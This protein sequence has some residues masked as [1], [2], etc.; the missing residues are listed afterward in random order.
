ML[1]GHLRWDN[2]TSGGSLGPA[3][4]ITIEITFK[5]VNK[6]TPDYTE[7]IARVV[8]ATTTIPEVLLGDED[9]AEVKIAFPVGGEVIRPNLQYIWS[10]VVLL[11]LAYVFRRYRNR[12]RLAEWERLDPS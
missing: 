8:N 11:L 4:S 5:A 12:R 6:T 10:I 7:N 9:T 2:I 3:N 1:P